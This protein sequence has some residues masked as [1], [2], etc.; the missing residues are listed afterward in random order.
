MED[1]RI[2]SYRIEATV[3]AMRRSLEEVRP[4]PAH[5]SA[6]NRRITHLPFSLFGDPDYCY[7]ETN[8]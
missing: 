6:R 5:D 1:A 4:F 7:K 2:V 8:N 3:V